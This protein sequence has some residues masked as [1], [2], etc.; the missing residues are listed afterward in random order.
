MAINKGLAAA[1]L[2]ALSMSGANAC[3][4]FADEMALAAAQQAAKAAQTAAVEP[5]AGA[6]V[7]APA[8]G[9]SEPA[10]SVATVAPQ[11]AAGQATAN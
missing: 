6:K 11:P 8:L 2:L 10:T 5:A 3:D 7:A 1:A 4:D 9:Q